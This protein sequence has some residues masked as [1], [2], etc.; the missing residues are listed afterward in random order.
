MAMNRRS[1]LHSLGAA[2]AATTLLPLVQGRGL[3]AAAQGTPGVASP[4]EIRLDSNENPYGPA[5]EVLRMLAGWY[6]ESGRYPDFVIQ[7]LRT[8]L[9]AHLGVPEDHLLLGCGSGELLKVS[10]EAFVSADRHAV[11]AS[12]TFETVQSRANA[13]KL[14]VRA[15]VVD[16]DLRIDLD[17]MVAAAP[18]A[19][20]VFFCNPNN[21]TGTLHL[22]AAI[23]DAT[24]R[25]LRSAP[26]AMVLIDEAYFEY[27]DDPGYRSL[28]PLAL[29]EPRVLVLRTFSKIYGL[30][31]LRL[32][33]VV[34]RPDA[35]ARMRP[36]LA[37]NN[38]NVLAAA[39][40]MASLP[41]AAHVRTEVARN[42]AVRQRTTRFFTDLGYTVVPSATNFVMV[43]VRRPVA[44]FRDA[45]RAWGVLPGRPFAPLDTHARIS[46]GTAEEMALAEPVFR[47][48][49]A[50]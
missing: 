30:A 44:A 39:A 11:T 16:K 14:P 33:Y 34:A 13:L 49:L 26:E 43:D 32:G 45:C 18:G 17:A 40:G 20:L 25:V 5:P 41:L 42:L 36:H 6:G 29:A 19:G 1:F 35:I 4:A 47:Q 28:I 38:V 50:G 23:E 7:N 3:E 22:S 12:P 2:G 27:V 24:M 8:T 48:V 10:V 9:A 15:P 37:P 21:P 31:G 46:L